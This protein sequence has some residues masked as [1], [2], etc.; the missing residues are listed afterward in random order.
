MGEFELSLPAE[1]EGA[2]SGGEE[3]EQVGNSGIPRGVRAGL[4]SAA[5]PEFA[6]C[7]EVGGQ[8][9]LFER[10]GSAGRHPAAKVEYQKSFPRA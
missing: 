8:T 3:G 4:E 9:L 1:V 2:P 10:A 5:D 7:H 6:G